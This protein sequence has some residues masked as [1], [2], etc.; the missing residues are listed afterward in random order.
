[1]VCSSQYHQN[2]HTVFASRNFNSQ[3]DKRILLSLNFF[4][5]MRVASVRQEHQ[6]KGHALNMVMLPIKNLRAIGI[7]HTINKIFEFIFHLND[8]NHMV[9]LCLEVDMEDN[10]NSDHNSV[11]LRASLSEQIANFIHC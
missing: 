1:M 10:F 5:F 3:N 4:K 2:A 7:T 11:E 8:E 6:G 9:P